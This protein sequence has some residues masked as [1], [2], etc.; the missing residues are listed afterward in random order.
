MSQRSHI[1]LLGNKAIYKDELVEIVTCVIQVWAEI[2]GR[3]L[4][5]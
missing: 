2:N 4:P 3:W 5:M 1:T